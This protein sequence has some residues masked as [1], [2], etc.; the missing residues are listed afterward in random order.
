VTAA[1]TAAVIS[2]ALAALV[3]LVALAACAAWGWL[4]AHHPLSPAVAAALCALASAVTF[5]RPAAWPLWL[6]PALVCTG[7]APFTG[8]LVVEELDLLLLALACGAYA[9]WALGWP[10]AEHAAHGLAPAGP[11][12]RAWI[13]WLW[14]ALLLVPVAIGLYRGVADA[15]GLRWGWWQGYREPLN[16]LRLAKPWLAWVLLLP[17]WLKAWRAAPLQMSASLRA[18]MV[19]MLA[20]AALGVWWE[21]W[22][23]IGLLNFSSDYRATGLFWEMHVGGAALDAVLALALPFAAAAWLDARS[24]AR[25]AALAAVLGLALYAAL[26]TFSRIVYLAVP[27]ALLATWALHTRL[28][29]EAAGAQPAANAAPVS[30]SPA[31]ALMWLV[32]T[33]ALGAAMFPTSGYRGLLALVAAAA[34]VLLAGSALRR[35]PPGVWLAGLGLGLIGTGAAAAATAFVWK[36]AYF[37]FALAWLGCAVLLLR[38]GSAAASRPAQVLL[39]AGLSTV[40]AALVAVAVHWGDAPALPASASAALGLAAVLAWSASRPASPWPVQWRWQVQAVGLWLA[41]AAVVG[42]FGGGAFMAQRIT[43]TGDDSQGRMAHWQRSLSW[44]TGDE[45]WLG[46]GLGRYASS[47]ALSGRPEDQVGDYRLQPDTGGSRGQTVVL[48]S[49]KHQLG[50]G[51]VFRLS[52][53]VRQPA[54]GPATLRLLLR[55]QQATSVMAEVCERHLLYISNCL[56]QRLDVEPRP[57]EW[58][59]VELRLAGEPPSRGAWLAPRLIVFSIALGRQGSRVEL[60]DLQLTDAAGQPLLSNGSFEQGLARWFSSS[61]RHHLPWHAKGL[62]VHLLFE[63][64]W[65]GLLCLGL[66]SAAALWRVSA[67]AARQHPLAPALAGALVGLW[68]VGGVD[69][70]INMPRVAWLMLLLLLCALTLPD[71]RLGLKSLPGP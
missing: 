5:A 11:D 36:G 24:P 21:R 4:A 26:T 65:L 44:L 9:R 17:L 30:R 6:L 45:L 42:V 50:Y 39:V 16:S 46:K 56:E 40:L 29:R 60:D 23:H 59:A 55:S 70:L 25:W 7:L 28:G 22:A 38:L 64:G 19:A 54:P 63:Q 57:G 8:W 35:P 48:T 18:G 15:G 53:Q 33:A 69:S 66:A 13:V 71:K 32:G 1:V 61:D 20:V 27:L 10:A 67:G 31:A 14:M 68:V 58:Q 3:A 37:S 43:N 49:G 34:L 41:A 51:E 47:Y 62:V 52:Q 2:R 12:A